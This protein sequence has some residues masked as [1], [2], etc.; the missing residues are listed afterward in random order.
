MSVI[1]FYSQI[2]VAPLPQQGASLR[3]ISR[4]I[5]TNVPIRKRTLELHAT[6]M[7]SN[8]IIFIIIV[9]TLTLVPLSRE[10]AV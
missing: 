3:R 6:E 1:S 2:R 4:H 7:S 5:T 9:M 8:F 10:A